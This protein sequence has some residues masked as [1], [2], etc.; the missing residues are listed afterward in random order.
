MDRLKRMKEDLIGC[1]QSQMY[2]LKHADAKELGEAI[3]MIKD[4]EEAIYYCTVT[5]AME[6]SKKEKGS[7]NMMNDAM[8]YSQRYAEPRFYREMDMDNG[9]MYYTTTHGGS[10]SNATN[11]R[12]YSEQPMR[13]YDSREGKSYMSRRNYMESKEMHHGKEKQM[14]ELEAYAQELTQDIMEM[15]REASPEE[16]QL[17]QQKIATLSTKI[18]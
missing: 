5:E 9:R 11:S 4:L 1:V 8:Y 17:L 2:D 7:T 13:M 12:M 3:D 10:G 15:I 14:K 6:E 18:K 16:K